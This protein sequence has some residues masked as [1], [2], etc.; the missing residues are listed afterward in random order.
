MIEFVTGYSKFFLNILKVIDGYIEMNPS[1]KEI[2]IP[3]LVEWS[4]CDVDHLEPLKAFSHVTELLFRTTA[5][6]NFMKHFS[7]NIWQFSNVTT[8]HIYL[9]DFNFPDWKMLRCVEHLPKL[10]EYI[11]SAFGRRSSKEFVMSFFENY[12]LP[13]G[14]KIVELSLE[15]VEWSKL[16]KFDNQGKITSNLFGEH[17][18]FRTFFK[19]WSK[20]NKLEKLGLHFEISSIPTPGIFAEAFLENLMESLTSVQALSLYFETYLL[21]EEEQESYFDPANPNPNY[22]LDFSRL[23]KP[24]TKAAPTLKELSLEYP[25]ISFEEMK[26]HNS[27]PFNLRSLSIKGACI[28]AD[29]I[30]F[31]RELTIKK[32]NVNINDLVIHN[33]VT[34]TKALGSFLSLSSQSKA[35]SNFCIQV[36]HADG[37]AKGLL[38]FLDRVKSPRNLTINYQ[39]EKNG[40]EGIRNYWK[41]FSW[42]RSLREYG[43]EKP[44]PLFEVF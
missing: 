18:C 14:I 3:N 13:R 11:L 38:S 36:G 20:V 42:I 2:I 22:V 19:H 7:Q 17:P 4:H 5:Q 25:I 1:F 23:L 27:D 21:Q 40:Y 29:E 15:F 35:K 12:T 9:E 37:I 26:K 34:H 30:A 6:C 44:S 32:C 10:E 16:L 33:D 8:L 24:I 39:V 28:A 31:I 43:N 41:G